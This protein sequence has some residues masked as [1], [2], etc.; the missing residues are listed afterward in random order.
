MRTARVLV[1]CAAVSIS[2][3]AFAGEVELPPEVTPAL[4]AACESDVR[5]IGCVDATPTYS[6]VKSCVIAKYA[7]L[8]KR[9]K[10]ELASAGYS[11]PSNMPK[12]GVKAD[13]I[14][15]ASA[16]PV[17]IKTLFNW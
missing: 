2:S 5:R 13:S 3:V 15:A 8:G 17:S 16:K 12:S 4:R 6:E 10:V 14:K 11:G 9:C 1:V 7:Q